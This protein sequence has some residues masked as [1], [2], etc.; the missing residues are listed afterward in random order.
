MRRMCGRRKEEGGGRTQDTRWA[1]KRERE[2]KNSSSALPLVARSFP[3]I[4][5]MLSER[6]R[7]SIKWDLLSSIEGEEEWIH[8]LT[9]STLFSSLYFVGHPHPKHQTRIIFS[10]F[11]VVFLSNKHTSSGT[12]IQDALMKEKESFSSTHPHLTQQESLSLP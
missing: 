1:K 3:V 6:A 5:I 7:E 12:R 10:P 8:M 2:R 4:I 9:H 11:S